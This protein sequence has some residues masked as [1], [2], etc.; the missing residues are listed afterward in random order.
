MESLL[1]WISY[2]NM[3]TL[4][5]GQTVL[6]KM[7]KN[8][9]YYGSMQTDKKLTS[10]YKKLVECPFFTNDLLEP[11][12][13]LSFCKSTNRSVITLLKKVKR[14]SQT[15]PYNVTVSLISI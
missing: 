10:I 5:K 2:G 7:C 9:L 1:C 6:H 3:D 4:L 15:Y 8:V 12:I 13:L 11:L 14:I